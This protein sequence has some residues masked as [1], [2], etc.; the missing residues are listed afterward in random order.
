MSIQHNYL[1]V[2]NL[3]FYQMCVGD[4][5]LINTVEPVKSCESAPD[6][7]MSCPAAHVKPT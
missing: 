2:C 6:D 1:S 3:N 5:T 4:L 7:V